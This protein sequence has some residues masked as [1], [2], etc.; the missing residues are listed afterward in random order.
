M[1][2]EGDAGIGLRHHIVERGQIGCCLRDALKLG[3]DAPAQI[4]R[5]GQ[6][7]SGEAPGSVHAAGLEA[8]EHVIA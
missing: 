7:K 2:V 4:T 3:G 8:G 6:R 1:E 5:A